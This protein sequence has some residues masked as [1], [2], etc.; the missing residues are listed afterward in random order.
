MVHVKT[1]VLTFTYLEYIGLHFSNVLNI[2]Q[3]KTPTFD[4]AIITC[5]TY[6]LQLSCKI[7]TIYNI[8]IIVNTCY[9]SNNVNYVTVGLLDIEVGFKPI[10]GHYVAIA[11]FDVGPL[12]KIMLQRKHEGLIIIQFFCGVKFSVVVAVFASTT[13]ALFCAQ[14]FV[15]HTAAVLCTFLRAPAPTEEFIKHLSCCLAIKKHW[16]CMEWNR[17]LRPAMSLWCGDLRFSN[18]WLLP[19]RSLIVSSLGMLLKAWFWWW[20]SV[21]LDVPVS[22]QACSEV[23]QI[24]VSIF[25]FHCAVI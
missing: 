2:Q 6:V 11:I 8:H 16:R 5:Y 23:V 15:S 18:V 25:M 13:H 19:Y 17:V 9:A 20:Q 10:P 4:D 7:Y 24:A 12:C 22:S 21:K 1:L 14:Q 3:L